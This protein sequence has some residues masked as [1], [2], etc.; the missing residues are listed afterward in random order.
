MCA[1]L[2]RDEQ[3]SQ[4]APEQRNRVRSGLAQQ[5]Y[6]SGAVKVH[7]RQGFQHDHSVQ[8]R[9][10]GSK[11]VELS[12]RCQPGGLDQGLQQGR[13]ISIHC[14]EFSNGCSDECLAQAVFNEAQ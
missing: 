9:F 7:K 2:Q 3:R 12:G 11:R 8:L 5:V 4:H 6:P 14:E 10:K 1:P 13:R